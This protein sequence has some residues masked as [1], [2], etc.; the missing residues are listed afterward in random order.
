M[1][2]CFGQIDLTKLGDI[3]RKH[4]SLV[5]KVTFKDGRE[6]QLLNVGLV[7]T[8][9]DNNG[10]NKALRVNCK[11]DE[12]IQGLNYFVGSLKEADNT[13]TQAVT[14]SPAPAN[15]EDDNDLPF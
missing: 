1:A 7:E 14:H 3:A 15:T 9:G 5:K 12:Q 8:R 13:N 6:H 2:Y 10:Y 11:Q 4:P